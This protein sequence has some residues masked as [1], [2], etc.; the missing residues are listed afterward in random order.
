MGVKGEDGLDGDID[1]LEAILLKHA[2]DHL[3]PVSLGV[4][5]G[6]GQHDLGVA[7]V[8]LELLVEGVVPEVTHVCPVLDDAVLHRVRH[9]EDRPQLSSFVAHHNILYG[10]I[11]DRLFCTQD[12]ATH[13]RGEDVLRE[14]GAGVT[15]LDELL[16]HA[17]VE[18]L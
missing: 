1:A 6:F 12:W 18:R 4:H 5:G 17:T 13:D 8:D 11:P 15:D 14:V 2:F 3:L 9:L 16:G 10:H 7:G